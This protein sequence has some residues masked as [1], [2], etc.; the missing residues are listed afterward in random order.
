MTERRASDPVIAPGRAL[1]L[2]TLT[3]GVLDILDAF[4]FFGL[5]NV[6]PI[7]ILQSIAG[8]LLGPSAFQGGVRTAAL[9]LLLHFTNAFLIVFGFFAFS[10][11]FRGLHQRP[12]LVGPV[13]GVLVYAVMNFVVIPLSAAGRGALTMPVVV[14]G[15]LIHILGVGT[16]AALFARAAF[17]KLAVAA[18][19]SAT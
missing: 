7:R 13:Y 19:V 6:A 5:R 17:G 8:G 9:G 4:I 2:G 14:N 10:R 16:P 12:W 11:R 15:L 3:V 18:R 1:L